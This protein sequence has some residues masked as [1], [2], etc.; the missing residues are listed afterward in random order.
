MTALTTAVRGLLGIGEHVPA[1]CVASRRVRR[2]VAAVVPGS[3]GITKGLVEGGTGSCSGRVWRALRK[4][5][6]AAWV[7]WISSRGE[8]RW[9]RGSL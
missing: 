3:G 1:A 9:M 6:S 5:K 4:T 8:S 7:V 2:R